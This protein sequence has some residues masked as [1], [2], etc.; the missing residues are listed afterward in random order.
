M[1]GLLRRRLAISRT[2]RRGGLRLMHC[3]QGRRPVRCFGLGR[4][5][6]G[7]G[8]KI[9]SLRGVLAAA[10]KGTSVRRNKRRFYGTLRLSNVRLGKLIIPGN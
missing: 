5:C 6:N 10:N 2:L 3:T 1:G 4:G 9:Q 7:L 8:V